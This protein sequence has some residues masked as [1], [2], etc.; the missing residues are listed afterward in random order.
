M[1]IVKSNQLWSVQEVN[2]LFYC[3]FYTHPSFKRLADKKSPIDDRKGTFLLKC[4]TMDWIDEGNLHQLIR[5][6][7]SS[8]ERLGTWC[9]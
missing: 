6:M 8:S 2:S 5:T 1:Q 9:T 4:F 3:H 7:I